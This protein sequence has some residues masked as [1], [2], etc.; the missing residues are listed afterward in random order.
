MHGLY[1]IFNININIRNNEKYSENLSNFNDENIDEK[2]F[3]N[4]YK[5]F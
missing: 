2:G 1:Q 5:I 4:L 3:A